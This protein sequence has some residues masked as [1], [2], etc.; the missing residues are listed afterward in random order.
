MFNKRSFSVQPGTR[1]PIMPMAIAGQI[2]HG[3]IR[4]GRQQGRRMDRVKADLLFEKLKGKS[5]GPWKLIEYRNHGKS[6]AVFRATDGSRDAALKIFDD[7]LIERYGDEIQ[8]AR[9]ERELTLIGKTHPNMVSILDGGYDDI[10]KSHYIVMEYLDGPNIKE[11]LSS[12]PVS[13]LGRLVEQ[14]ASAARFLE[15]EDL[16]HRDI[17]PENIVILDDFKRL[18]LLDFGVLR[19]IGKPGLTDDDGIQNFVG[20]LQYSSPE[21]LL[22]DEMD[23]VDGWR[24]LTFYQIGAV[25]HDMIMGRE[26]FSEFAVPYS[27]LVNA[28]QDN[29][30]LIQS[31][32]VDPYLVSLARSCLLKDPGKR[33]KL[34]NWSSFEVPSDTVGSAESAKMRVTNRAVVK[35]AEYDPTPMIPDVTERQVVN[36]LV[37]FL[38][39]ACRLIERDND[40][41]PRLDVV[42]RPKHQ[43]AVILRLRA[44]DSHDLPLDLTIITQIEVVEASARAITLSAAGHWG[45]AAESEAPS[46]QPFF[47]GL[48]DTTNIRP[49]F[50]E[51][52][53]ELVDLAQHQSNPAGGMWIDA[54]SV[55]G[56]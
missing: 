45:K 35:R 16:V 19:P 17:K 41:F 33:L 1:L 50:E 37:D 15:D 23:T 8:L 27:R 4:D 24:A 56:E 51:R 12:I 22:R 32:A 25:L 14:L 10:T 52:L 44:S 40:A 36:E 5:V 34:L 28:V 2:G 21:F 39:E 13:S 7:E 38:K 46:T 6:A 49:L 47:K 42:Y 53:Y 43:D 30:P 31:S 48:Y 20:T 54:V 11:C 18:V 9:I 26:L 3:S 29:V 55:L